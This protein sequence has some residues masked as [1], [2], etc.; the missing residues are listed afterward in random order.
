MIL[1]FDDTI[2]SGVDKDQLIYEN[3][4][5]RP[6]AS[7]PLSWFGAVAQAANWRVRLAGMLPSKG[8]VYIAVHP[9]KTC[10][11]RAI[12]GYPFVYLYWGGAHRQY[13]K[14][15]MTRI[16]LSRARKVFTNE[17]FG[18]AEVLSL[19]G[20]A[21]EIVDYGFDTDFFDLNDGA[22]E[23]FIFCPGANDRDE[24]IILGL[25]EA[26][27]S[28]VWLNNFENATHRYQG[29][30]QNLEIIQFPDFLQ[31]KRL[32]QTAAC[33]IN[34]LSKD[35][36][37]AGQ[38]TTLEALGCGA[39]VVLSPGRT[40]S[41]FDGIEQVSICETSTADAWFLAIEQAI[42]KAQALSP[43]AKQAARRLMADRWDVRHSAQRFM[44]YLSGISNL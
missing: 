26:G 17:R 43:K 33:V 9:T 13:F 36:H 29:K 11:A 44:S 30:S 2:L 20:R 7:K 41:I 5:N 18:V 22:R 28:V 12:L 14:L 32:Y 40:S 38:T 27:Y 3:T 15:I 8:S 21:A 34:P 23:S 35:V 6:D 19:S 39:P 25:C 24:G 37:A 31:L 42:G 4:N 10:L 16:I 1:E